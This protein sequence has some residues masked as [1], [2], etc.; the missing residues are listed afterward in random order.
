MLALDQAARHRDA[1]GHPLPVAWP[2]LRTQGVERAYLTGSSGPLHVVELVWEGDLEARL[3]I[4]E[5]R[6]LLG[7][8]PAGQGE[9]VTLRVSSP[10]ED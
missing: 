10:E 5:E 2:T 9:G 4:D 1:G 7:L 6:A 3:L 8:L